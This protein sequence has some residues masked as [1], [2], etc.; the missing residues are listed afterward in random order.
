M[1]TRALLSY[2]SLKSAFLAFVTSSHRLDACGKVSKYS[3]NFERS[4]HAPTFWS[5]PRLPTI[6]DYILITSHCIDVGSVCVTR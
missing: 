2:V 5:S 6:K 3:P 1:L 4:C